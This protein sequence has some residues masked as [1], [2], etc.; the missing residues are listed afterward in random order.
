MVW[1]PKEKGSEAGGSYR[2]VAPTTQGSH[3]A[4]GRMG[5]VPRA[6]EKPHSWGEGATPEWTPEKALNDRGGF[7]G[8]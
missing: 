6:T 8:E 7:G 1:V 2:K 3:V 5:G 4:T